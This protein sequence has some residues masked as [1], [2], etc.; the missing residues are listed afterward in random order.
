MSYLRR[1]SGADGVVTACKRPLRVKKGGNS[2]LAAKTQGI[3][4]R[5][6]VRRRL[7]GLA[8]NELQTSALEVEDGKTAA[9]YLA[10]IPKKQSTYTRII[11][12][13]KVG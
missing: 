2:R 13:R 7:R 11:A 12:R 6:F 4:G 1:G 8:D 5:Q 3:V 10:R 9:I